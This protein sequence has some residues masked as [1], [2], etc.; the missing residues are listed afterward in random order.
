[1]ID[2]R[3]Q[4]S[5]FDPGKQI[6]RLGTLGLAGVAGFTGHVAGEELAQASVEHYAAIAKDQLTRIA[7]EAAGRWSL[8]GAILI[9]RFGRFVP[10]DRLLFA[11]TATAEP[12]AAL[13][14]CRYLVEA[15]R[16]RA[17]FWR[18]DVFAD[19]SSRWR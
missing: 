7:E 15:L 3:V 9:H 13:E 14:A 6:E 2:V 12:E 16:T 5:D 11:G 8:G 4:T 10:G 17:P 1:M 19:G 18:K